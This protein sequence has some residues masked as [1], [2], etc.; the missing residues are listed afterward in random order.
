MFSFPSLFPGTHVPDIC[1]DVA[2]N[3]FLLQKGES[4][5]YKCG[6]SCI[7]YS[8]KARSWGQELLKKTESGASFFQN[9]PFHKKLLEPGKSVL[10]FEKQTNKELYGC[11]TRRVVLV[12]NALSRPQEHGGTWRARAGCPEGKPWEKDV[13]CH[14]NHRAP[15]P[16]QPAHCPHLDKWKTGKLI[17]DKGLGVRPRAQTMTSAHSQLRHWIPVE[18]TLLPRLCPCPEPDRLG[19][20]P[21]STTTLPHYGAPAGSTALNR[22]G[23]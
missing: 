14:P 21:Q 7:T 23:Q 19:A 6:Y 15:I 10:L 5:D 9:I 2:D 18:I 13:L 12:P 11:Q 8:E 16:W 3:L 1:T 4:Q 22:G 17:G 20:P